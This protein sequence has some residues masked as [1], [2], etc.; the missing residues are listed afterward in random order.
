MS[1]MKRLLSMGL[2]A[3]FVLSAMASCANNE[4]E[5]K[6]SKTD[7]VNTEDSGNAPTFEEADFDQAEFKILH[8]GETATDFHDQYIWAEDYTGGTIG[9]AVME[10]NQL[11][12]DRYNVVITAEECSPMGEATKRMQ[13]GQCDFDLIYEWGIRSKSAALDGMLYNFHEL[14]YIDLEQSY[15]VPNAVEKLTVADKMFV[16][17][18]LISMNA[19]SWAGFLFFN[20]NMMD[21]LNIEYPYDNV[22]ENSW[23]WDVMIPMLTKAE[24]DV[25]GDGKMNVEDQYGGISGKDILAN[26]CNAPLVIDNGDGSYTLNPYTEAM[27]A[28]YDQYR[29]LVESIDTIDQDDVWDSGAD[30]SA[31]P[32]KYVGARFVIFGEDH[33]LFAGGNMDFTKEFTNMKSDYGIVPYPV[34]TA[35]DEYTASIDYCAPMFSLP[36]QLEDPDMAA[37]VIEYMAYESEQLLLPA[38]YETTIKT[39]RM[40]DT[41]DY[42]MLDII[43]NSVDYNWMGIYMW[44]KDVYSLREKMLSSGNFASVAKRYSNKCQ[45]EIDEI[46]ETIASI[47]A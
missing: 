26:I 6:P 12:E 29:N 23:T 41:R 28:K 20:K 40:Q 1:I 39:K 17:T 22:Y 30:M 13:A 11:V 38:Y 42:D 21:K 46:V 14:N 44:D 7:K 47:D 4:E 3:A 31:Y 18:N 19:I 15:W 43:R 33:T 37:M 36:I 2:A 35:G 9:D 8:Y 27:V 25:N 24:E 32:S 45:A 5:K 10:R 16:G 34:V